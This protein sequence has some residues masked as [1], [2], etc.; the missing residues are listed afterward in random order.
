MSIWIDHSTESLRHCAEQGE[1]TKSHRLMMRRLRK[2]LLI[3]SLGFVPVLAA[4]AVEG[5]LNSLLKNSPFESGASTTGTKSNEP[6]EFRG[7]LTESGVAYF[8]I[9]ETS[10]SRS[11]WVRLNEDS[12]RDY[13]AKRYDWAN[14]QLTIEYQGRD[15]VLSLAA[16]S[17][18]APIATP[19]VTTP[20]SAG[21]TAA[22]PTISEAQ[23][24]NNIAAEIKRRR[25]LRQQAIEQTKVKQ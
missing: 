9:Y 17:S 7:V 14:R 10:T 8:S 2:T 4:W 15:L 22:K 3:A 21:S 6:L 1:P 16:D 24:L 11:A 13:T 12:S 20:T 18:P 23:K 19:A 5:D 25:A